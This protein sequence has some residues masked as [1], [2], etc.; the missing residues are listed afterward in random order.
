MPTTHTGFTH[1]HTHTHARGLHMNSTGM[2]ATAQGAQ[3]K[4]R[5][6]PR[7][8][9]TPR[10]VISGGSKGGPP[11]GPGPHSGK[12]ATTTGTAGERGASRGYQA[13][14]SAGWASLCPGARGAGESHSPPSALR[15]AADR[16]SRSRRPR[17]RRPRSR[18]SRRSLLT[19][20][21]CSTATPGKAPLAVS[22]RGIGPAHQLP[23]SPG[24]VPH[25]TPNRARGV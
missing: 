20:R 7:P 4:A 11:P 16:A 15:P 5:R 9:R 3:G 14:S 23:S 18:C 2:R 12:L 6:Q 22:P 25:R 19:S 1:T 24:R 21:I 13:Q 10:A 17:S 8:R